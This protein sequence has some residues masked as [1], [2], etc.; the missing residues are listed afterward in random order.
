MG[1][2][3]ICE[4][5]IFGKAAAF[6]VIKRDDDVWPGYRLARREEV[7][8]NMEK[9]QMVITDKWFIVSLEDGAIY[10]SGYRWKITNEKKNH[11]HKLITKICSSGLN[12]TGD[13][14]A[15]LINQVDQ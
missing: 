2:I 14:T 12:P 8:R 5:E 11:G 6:V 10:G 3:N 9:V 1:P 4:V 7:K 13:W 15:E